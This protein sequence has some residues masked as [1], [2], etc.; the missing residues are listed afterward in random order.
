MGDVEE[1]EADFRSVDAVQHMLDV[2]V[3][4]ALDEGGVPG[5]AASPA[6]VITGGQL[7]WR[8]QHL[9]QLLLEGQTW[10]REWGV[11]QSSLRLGPTSFEKVVKEFRR[12]RT[13][14]HALGVYRVERTD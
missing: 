7:P 8:L 5:F 1:G 14:R 11:L 6:K 10:G 9:R 4:E 13:H 2:T 3:H 12:E